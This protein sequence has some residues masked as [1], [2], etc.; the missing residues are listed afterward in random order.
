MALAG[1]AACL[2]PPFVARALNIFA[3]PVADFAPWV[4]VQSVRVH[5]FGFQSVR[6]T[7]SGFGFWVSDFGSRVSGF[8][9]WVAGFG[10]QYCMRVQRA[11][12]QG[13]EGGGGGNSM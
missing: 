6:F 4:K 2:P 5:G 8:G 9:F 11:G 1:L 12:C 7:I 3:P 10:F 13:S